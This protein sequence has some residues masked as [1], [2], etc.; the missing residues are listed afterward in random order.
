MTSTQ[1]FIPSIQ[2]FAISDTIPFHLQLTGSIVSL[3]ELL[4]TSSPLL[5]PCDD[6]QNDTGK[7][8]DILLPPVTIQVT[9]SRQIMIEVNGRR[10]ARSFILSEGKLW[11]VPPCPSQLQK[12]GDSAKNKMVH[13][14]C[15]KTDDVSLDWQGEVKCGPQVRFGGF[16]T[17]HV[18]FKVRNRHICFV[19]LL[20]FGS[21][22]LSLEDI[23]QSPFGRISSFWMFF[24]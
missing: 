21:R 1:I 16:L 17:S 19:P 6:S 11:P 5:L 15:E 14:V 3:R 20:S 4:P 10:K 2:T 18:S 12:S 24:D 7:E 23:C 9:I 13:D 8:N 22:D